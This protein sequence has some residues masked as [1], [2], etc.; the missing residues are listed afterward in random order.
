MFSQ[1]T[2]SSST[3]TAVTSGSARCTQ[4]RVLP[5]PANGSST[6]AGGSGAAPATSAMSAAMSS[7]RLSR[8]HSTIVRPTSRTPRS[9]QPP[10]VM[11]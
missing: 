10:G 11:P 8:V 5:E 1:M 6:S 9:Y 7:E 4:C 2:G 3:P